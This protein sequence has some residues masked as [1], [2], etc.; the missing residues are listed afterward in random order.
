MRPRRSSSSSDERDRKR[1]RDTEERTERVYKSDY[2]RVGRSKSTPANDSG[3]GLR[4]KVKSTSPEREKK[5]K[6]HKKKSKRQEKDGALQQLR[7]E[8]E[9]RETRE[10]QRAKALM[11]GR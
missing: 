2:S 7:R 3:N 11:G 10:R 4:S 8:R 6:K 9:E 5:P 1:S